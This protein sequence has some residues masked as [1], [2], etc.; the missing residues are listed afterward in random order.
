MDLPVGV[1]GPL[2]PRLVRVGCDR[3]HGIVFLLAGKRHNSA[4]GQRLIPKLAI[5]TSLVQVMGNNIQFV[6]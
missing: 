6:N 1:R 2:A 3:G 4:T 5:T